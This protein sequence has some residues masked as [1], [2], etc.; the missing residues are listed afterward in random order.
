MGPKFLTNNR[1]RGSILSCK[2]WEIIHIVGTPKERGKH[3]FSL[4][5]YGFFRKNTLNLARQIKSKRSVVYKSVAYR[6][7]NII[8]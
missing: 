2:N 4:L 6:S 7:Y 1:C 5:V 3:W 8:F